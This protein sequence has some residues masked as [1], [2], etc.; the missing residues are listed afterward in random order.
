MTTL[1]D[2]VPLIERGRYEEA[3]ERIAELG[4]PLDRIEAITRI[5]RRIHLD[6]PSDWI[7]ELV[8]DAVYIIERMN[9]PSDRVAGYA[10]LAS[11]LSSIGYTDEAVDF[12]DLAVAEADSIGEPLER[13]VSTSILAYYLAVSGYP[14][15]ALETFNAAFDALVGAEVAYRLKVDGM[16]RIA[17]LMEK[18]G[19]GLPSKDALEF[20]RAA[21]DIFD[22]L[23]VNQRAAMVEKRIELVKTLYD[24]GLPTI[25]EAV[26]EGRNHYALAL[27][28]KMY[29]GVARLIGYLEVALWLKRVN[30][31]EYLDIVD[32][33]FKKCTRPRFT[34]SN[35][36]LIARLLTELGNLKEALKFATGIADVRKRSEVMKA[37]AFELL[38]RD[39]YEA[40][41]KVA[42]SIPDPVVR[43]ETIME[44]NAVRG[45][46]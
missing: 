36:Q 41:I 39:D 27:I 46:G 12:F 13:A 44:I 43:N 8:E 33:A 7:P 4:D 18:A 37:I 5:I 14:E 15:Q 26:L 30:N 28:D 1:D 3:I 42:K 29:S 11:T 20:Y 25:R 2:V 9:D 32:E 35:V 40:A 17:E 31:P 24:V 38:A 45:E 19:D 6:G 21:F 10:L 22:K 23:S 16:I 34:D